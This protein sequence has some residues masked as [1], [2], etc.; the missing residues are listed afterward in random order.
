MMVIRVMVMMVA[1]VRRELGSC[2]EDQVPAGEPIMPDRISVIMLQ[3][4][5][6]CPMDDGSAEAFALPAVVTYDLKVVVV[7]VVVMKILVKVKALS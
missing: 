3:S 6:L 2:S 7:V 1:E 5:L 4:V